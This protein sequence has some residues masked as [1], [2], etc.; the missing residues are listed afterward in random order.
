MFVHHNTL[1]AYQ[2]LP[3]HEGVQ[4][5]A[6]ALGAEPYLTLPAFRAAWRDGRIEDA[7]LQRRDRP[8]ARPTGRR[9]VLGPLTGA[10]LWHTLMATSAE[11]EDAA[12]LAYTIHAGIAPECED[13]P[14]WQA[15]LARAERGPGF[16]PPD[17][18]RFRRHRDVLVAL[19]GDDTDVVVH[20]ELIRLGAGFLDHGHAHATLPGR[21]RG[22]LAA[23]AALYAGGATAPRGCRGAEADM[24]A[25]IDSGA[26][27]AGV[28]TAALDLLGVTDDEVEPVLF[29]TALALPGWAGMFSRLE[30]HPRRARRDHGA[31]AGR[32]RGRAPAL[33]AIGGGPRCRCSW[34][35]HRLGRAAMARPARPPRPAVLDGALLWGIA[36][37]G[38]FSAAD[39]AAWSDAD[40]TPVWREMRGL[41]SGGAATGVPR[42]LRAHL[43][44]RGFSMRSPPAGLCRRRGPPTGRARSSC[45]ASTSARSRS[46]GPSRSSTRLHHLRRCRVLRRRHRLP[47][48]LRRARRRTAPWW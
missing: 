38:G 39:V 41:L 32:V 14:L 1:H 6:A 30:R 17:V 48:P 26:D 47:G 43:P 25:V 31:D 10:E 29:A 27:A 4:A 36:R 2:H 35:A 45:S 15:C 46:G 23:V 3:F 16:A 20:G 7:D 37:A 24:Q 21:D 12:G 5:G 42:G 34:R 11:S 13:L 22:F 19:G 40:L 44:A 33:R 8:R 28:I 9:S 18:R